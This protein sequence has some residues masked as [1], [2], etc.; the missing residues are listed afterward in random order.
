MKISID[1]TFLDAKF[2]VVCDRAC[3]AVKGN[4]VLRHA[5]IAQADWG[6]IPNHP[7]IAA[8]VVNQPNPMPSEVE[9]LAYV[10]SADDKPVRV[11]DVKRLAIERS[12]Q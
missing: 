1:R 6:T 8:F 3:K 4:I 10:E 12:N 11:L 7:E 5:G 9:F 2:A